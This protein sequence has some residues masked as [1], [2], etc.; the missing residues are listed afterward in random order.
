VIDVD[1]T[2]MPGTGRRMTRNLQNAIDALGDSA[3]RTT[4]AAMYVAS[5]ES[6]TTLGPIMLAMAR[7]IELQGL[8]EQA[9]WEAAMRAVAEP[10]PDVPP[11]PGPTGT[12]TFYF[13]PD[14]DGVLRLT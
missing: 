5:A 3:R 4:V 14:D 1:Q 11:L 8:R 13:D 7:E 6:T 9:A 10:E 2:L 12:A